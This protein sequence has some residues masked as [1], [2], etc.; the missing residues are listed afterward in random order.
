VDNSKLGRAVRTTAVLLLAALASACVRRITNFLLRGATMMCVVLAIGEANADQSLTCTTKDNFPPPTTLLVKGDLN[1]PTEIIWPS[2]AETQTYTFTSISDAHYSAIER[3]PKA[4]DSPSKIF[5]NRLT[6][7]LVLEN[8][9]SHEARDVLV[10]ACD[11]KITLDQCKKE[12]RS[13][14]GG[15]LFACPSSDRKTSNECAR[16]KNGSNLLAAFHYVCVPT[17]RKF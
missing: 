7:E 17:Q 16:W 11:G 1:A 5:I 4:Q 10:K 6:G 12:Q 2:S 13:I 3:D 9:I 14:K 15:N 8:F